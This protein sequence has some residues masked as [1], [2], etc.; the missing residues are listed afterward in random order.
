METR[1]KMEAPAHGWAD[2]RWLKDGMAPDLEMQVLKYAVGR[3]LNCGVC[4]GLL[5][6]R[7]AV[8]VTNDAGTGVWCAKCWDGMTADYLKNGTPEQN[9]NILGAAIRGEVIDGRSPGRA[10]AAPWALAITKNDADNDNDKEGA[11]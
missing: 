11:A 2:K 3:A 1:K 8:C 9:R 5:D 10:L 6:A 7:R 4:A